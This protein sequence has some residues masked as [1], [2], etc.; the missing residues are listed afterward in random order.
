M[1]VPHA[2][3]RD[4]ALRDRLHEEGHAV[5]SWLDAGQVRALRAI[6]DRELCLEA[7]RGGMHYTVYSQDLDH[8]R[9]VHE[10]IAAVLNPLL[11]HRF[12]DFTNVVNQFVV[13]LPGPASEFPPHQDTT[14]VDERKFSPL[15]LWIP[16]SDVTRDHGCLCVMPRSHRFLSP[17]RGI[18]FG[19]PFSGIL[20]TVRRYLQPLPLEAGEILVFDPRI[21]HSSLPN[22]GP[23]MRVAVV[24]GILPENAR[25]R[26]CFREPAPEG[27]PIE[28][29]EQEDDYV[30]T[31]PN[32]LHDCHGRPTTGTVVGQ[33]DLPV[34]RLEADRFEALCEEY[35]IPPVEVLPPAAD[36]PCA[37][38]GEPRTPG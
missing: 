5:V 21:I 19:F 22:R 3:V 12:R 13:K 24:S 34:S 36:E 23:E 8:R 30:L 10:E 7:P 17:Y 25:I 14:I 35:G 2:V 31:Y 28:I 9:R 37:M 16:L 1:P 6:A 38:L 18:S 33:A 11:R 4:P 26:V 29:F 32:F 27:M 20:P 15:S